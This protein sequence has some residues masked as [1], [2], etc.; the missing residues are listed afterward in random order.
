MSTSPAEGL[1]VELTCDGNRRFE[2]AMLEQQSQQVAPTALDEEQA[3][4]CYKAG[5]EASKRIIETARDAR[6]GMMALWAWSTKNW[7]RPPHQ[8][9]AVFR[10]MQEFLDDLEENWIDLPENSDVRL[11]HMGRTER[12]HVEQSQVMEV[13][14]RIVQY[15]KD[16]TGMVVALLLDYAGPDEDK[17][18]RQLWKESGCAG[19]F[20]D[21]LDLPRAGVSYR[22]LD[23]RIRTG[24]DERMKHLN[25]VMRPYEGMETRDAFHE[26]FLPQ[27]TPALFRQ[28]LDD[29]QKTEQRKGA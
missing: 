7:S 20:E 8:T 12:L 3:Y 18:A 28:D 14:N 17:R 10:V 21:H 1:W 16:R 19:A 5:G 9:R 26:E 15:T 29:L 25:A 11:V 27:Y 2:A 23:L 24:E 4:E 13:L 22:E 6:V